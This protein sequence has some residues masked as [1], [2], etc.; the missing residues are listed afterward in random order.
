MAQPTGQSKTELVPESET[1]FVVRTINAELTFERDDKGKVNRFTL[2]QGTQTGLATRIEPFA[3]DAA[4]LGEYTGDYYSDELGT[5][6]SFVVK[7]GKLIA[8]HR[9]HNDITMTPTVVDQFAGNMW[10]FGRVAFTRDTEKRITGFKLSGGRVRN[11]R[12]LKHSR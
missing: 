4:A 8:Q 10:F 11:L 3:P 2:R 1:R 6:Y 9:R 5:V 12:F 7:D